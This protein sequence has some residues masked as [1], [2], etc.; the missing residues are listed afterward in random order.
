MNWEQDFMF[1]DPVVKRHHPEAGLIFD[2]QRFSIHDG[3]GIRTNIYLKGCSLRCR[4]CANPES[5]GVKPELMMIHHNCIHCGRCVS[6]CPTGSIGKDDEGKLR[7]NKASCRMPECGLCERACPANAMVVIGRYVTASDVVELALRDRHFYARTGGG[8]TFT[9]GEPL[10]QSAFVASCADRLHERGISTAVETAGF[11]PWDEAEAVFRR[12][13]TILFDVKHMDS[14]IHKE[15]V[16]VPNEAIHETLRRVDSVGCPIRVRLPLI[17]GVNDSLENVRATAALALSL[18]NL[19]SLDLLPYHRM[20]E[21]KWDQIQRTYLLSGLE[22]HR[23][24]EVE[25][26]YEAVR[27]MGAPATIGG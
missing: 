7:V 27:A 24:E 11:A 6:V 22:P 12:M 10:L 19:Q 17:P 23:R 21:P 26:L 14:A 3:P 18:K 16:G 2:V 5:W 9:G 20:G 8:V 4:W 1:F 25:P 15:Y 13:D